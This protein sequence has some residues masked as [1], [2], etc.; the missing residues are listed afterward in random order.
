MKKNK[1]LIDQEI[2]EALDYRNENIDGLR[3]SI[4]HDDAEIYSALFAELDKPNENILGDDFAD[5]VVSAAQK[6]KRIHDFLWKIALYAGVSIPLIAI[7]A[8]VALAMDADVFWRMFDSLKSSS[9]YI[10]FSIG[11]F[12]IIQILDKITLKNNTPEIRT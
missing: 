8:I 9:V 1:K 12:S 7:S 3:H 5:T 10:L 4:A 6:K 2:Q 11:L